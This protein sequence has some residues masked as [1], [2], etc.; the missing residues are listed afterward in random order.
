MLGAAKKKMAYR[1][2]NS[3]QVASLPESMNYMQLNQ[4]P[5]AFIKRIHDKGDIVQKVKLPALAN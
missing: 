3:I 5:D 2:K 1:K 4:A